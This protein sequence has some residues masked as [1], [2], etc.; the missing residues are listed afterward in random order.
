MF[1]K[2]NYF[3]KKECKKIIQFHKI[4]KE[5][6]FMYDWYNQTYDKNNRIK[7]NNTAAFC[8]YLIPNTPHTK[9]MFDKIHRFFEDNTGIKFTKELLR[10]QLYKYTVGDVFPKHIDL[11]NVHPRRRWNLGINLN[12]EYEGGEYLCWNGMKEDDSLEIIPKSAGTM[13]GYHSKQ[14]HEIKKIT[15]GERWSLVIKIESEFIDEE[16]NII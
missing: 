7:L 9:W 8:A 3:T 13:C 15:K 4:Y 16:I 14:L 10:C 5:Y 2:K 12:E 11:S 1:Y 6:G